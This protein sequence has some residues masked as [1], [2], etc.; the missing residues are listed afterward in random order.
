MLR[1]FLQESRDSR[2]EVRSR[3]AI[4]RLEHVASQCRGPSAVG[5]CD[6]SLLPAYSLIGL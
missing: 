5:S 4:T 1:L 2:E 6:L 3:D